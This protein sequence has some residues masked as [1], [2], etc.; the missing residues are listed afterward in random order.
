ME[1][2]IPTRNS[3]GVQKEQQYP[4]NE[5]ELHGLRGHTRQKEQ[6]ST[7]ESSSHPPHFERELALVTCLTNRE[8]QT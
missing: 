2:E 1:R 7:E 8:Q 4:G 5:P 6:K 3:R